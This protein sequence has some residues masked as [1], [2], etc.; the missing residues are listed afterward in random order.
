MFYV[1]T[2]LVIQ[3]ILPQIEFETLKES[4]LFV[5]AFFY[6]YELLKKRHFLSSALKNVLSCHDRVN[7]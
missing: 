5:C 2:I 4:I 7:I 1:Q 3:E 6:Q